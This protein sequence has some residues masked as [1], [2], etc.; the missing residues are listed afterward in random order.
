MKV[1]EADYKALRALVG[2]VIET[3]GPQRVRD[4]REGLRRCAEV[5]DHQKRMRWDLLWAVERDKRE[6]L[7]RGLYSYCNDDHIDT[8]LKAIIKE[9]L[10]EL[11]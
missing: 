11:T 6:P 2:E 3:A 5:A 8:A 1:T 10:P 9:L 7:I 4:Y